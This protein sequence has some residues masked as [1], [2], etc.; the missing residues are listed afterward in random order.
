V[1]AVTP[2]PE[3]RHLL[4]QQLFAMTL[5]EGRVSPR[6]WAEELPGLDRLDPAGEV[7]AHLVDRGL[8]V[9]DGDLYILGPQA[10]K[11]YG[12]R[13][14]SELTSM[15]TAD[16]LL[17]V[18]HG[19]R[20]LGSLHP[21]SLRPRKEGPPIVLLGGRSWSVTYTDWRRHQVFVE[22]A[23]VSGRSRWAG[24]PVALSGTVCRAARSVL[25]GGELGGLLSR[26]ASAA[27]GEM[28]EGMTWAEGGVTAVVRE[29]NGELSWWTF[30][31]LLANGQLAMA[32]GDGVADPDRALSNVSLRLRRDVGAQDLG[33]A[34]RRA[35]AEPLPAPDVG[36]EMV[37]DL[38]F[39]T[40][41]PAGLARRTCAARFAD[42]A[43]AR[44]ALVERWKA[45][46]LSEP[47]AVAPW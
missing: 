24:G 9:P 26:R 27:L 2:P 17:T 16:P 19:R 14:F 8:L 36:E 33:P 12:R 11:D 47:L 28:R 1:E 31:G 41:L 40:A 21:L 45:V 44:E 6:F 5:Q 39:G 34:L 35:A 15:F 18:L 46:R 43:S 29:E 38:K 23:A 22:P 42:P 13:A 32:L 3:P 4:A 20:E 7:I 10:E 30:A 25:A 37:R